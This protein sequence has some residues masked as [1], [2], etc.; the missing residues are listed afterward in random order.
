[1][2][3]ALESRLASDWIGGRTAGMGSYPPINVFQREDGFVAVIE[4]PGIDKNDIEIEAKECPIAYLAGRASTTTR[5]PACTGASACRACSTGRSRCP[6]RST[7]TPLR[8]STAMAC[9]RSLSA[10][11]ERKAADHQ[12]YQLTCE[13]TPHGYATRA[14]SSAKARSGEQAGSDDPRACVRSRDRHLRDG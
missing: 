8:P 13:S 6:F 3:K 1:M 14:A 9:Y 11:G 10:G 5:R 2:Q 7:R 12:D 4:L